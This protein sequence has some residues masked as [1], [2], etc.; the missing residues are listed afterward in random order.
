MIPLC[1]SGL[2]AQKV[3]LFYFSKKPIVILKLVARL[4]QLWI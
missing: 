3:K 4:S 1:R 2:K